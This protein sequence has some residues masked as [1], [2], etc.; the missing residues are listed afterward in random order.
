MRNVHVTWADN[1]LTLIKRTAPRIKKEQSYTYLP[2]PPLR[3]SHRL[4]YGELHFLIGGVMSLHLSNFWKLAYSN[5]Y[6]G[7][8]RHHA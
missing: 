1:A 5:V 8:S 4:F 6:F 2:P 7:I 3:P